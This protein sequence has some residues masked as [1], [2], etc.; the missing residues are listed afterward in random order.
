MSPSFRRRGSCLLRSGSSCGLGSGVA[1]DILT[2]CESVK[3]IRGQQQAHQVTDSSYA[4]QQCTLFYAVQQCKGCRI[5][6]M[7]RVALWAGIRNG[8]A[9]TPCQKHPASAISV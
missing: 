9:A 4:V 5:E 8:R 3:S 1:A 6:C 7:L 2:P